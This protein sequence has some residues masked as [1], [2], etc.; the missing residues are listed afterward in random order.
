VIDPAN[1]QFVNGRVNWNQFD[2]RIP[3]FMEQ[4]YVTLG[5]DVKAK[6]NLGFGTIDEKG[7]GETTRREGEGGERQ[8]NDNGNGNNGNDEVNS[9]V[10]SESGVL[11]SKVYSGPTTECI[12]EFVSHPNYP[13]MPNLDNEYDDSDFNFGQLIAQE[14]TTTVQEVSTTTTTIL[15]SECESSVHITSLDLIENNYRLPVFTV[16]TSD[17]E[18]IES[19]LPPEESVN[20]A[21]PN[22]ESESD[23]LTTLLADNGCGNGDDNELDFDPDLVADEVFEMLGLEK[24]ASETETVCEPVS[25]VETVSETDIATAIESAMH[26]SDEQLLVSVDKLIGE[27]QT[28]CETTKNRELHLVI[29]RIEDCA[30][31][32]KFKLVNKR[33]TFSSEIDRLERRRLVQRERR[34]ARRAGIVEA[35]SYTIQSD[36]DKKKKAALKRER[37]REKQLKKAEN[38]E[39]RRERARVRMEKK[40]ETEVRRAYAFKNKDKVMVER[41]KIRELTK[42]NKM[43]KTNKLRV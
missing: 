36:E 27:W 18:L 31:V 13:S 6:R 3:G 26:T 10:N 15:Q 32:S 23:L 24:N 35:R 16:L 14:V 21:S 40:K 5:V 37:Q 34:K 38:A 9:K 11:I 29:K 30:E 2:R 41:L 1:I 7:E 8:E 39:K 42:L 4:V 33:I 12:S 25:E 20:S 43:S 28:V 22:K 17:Y 19:L